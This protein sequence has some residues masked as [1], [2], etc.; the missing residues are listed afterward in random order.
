MFD[1][2]TSKSV[3]YIAYSNDKIISTV[4]LYISEKPANPHNIR[5]KTGEVLNVITEPDFR[6]KGIA[7]KLIKIML[8]DAR[9]MKLSAVKLDATDM[10][11]TMYLKAGFK[12]EKSRYTAMRFEL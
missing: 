10:G 1:R 2:Y 4:L 8:D 7:Q 6:R 12:P 5:S 3:A 9:D 11:K